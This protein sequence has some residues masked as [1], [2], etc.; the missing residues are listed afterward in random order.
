[1]DFH[2][3]SCS[4]QNS[5]LFYTAPSS[6]IM[7]DDST[8]DCDDHEF[9]FEVTT[10]RFTTH[11]Q[12]QQTYPSFWW[13]KRNDSEHGSY[14]LPARAKSFC[15]G[16]VLPLKPPPRLQTSACS[17]PRSPNSLR[18][19]FSRPCAWND[20]FDPFQFALEK[21]SDETRAR[22]SFHRR[23]QSYS[24]YRTSSVAHWLEGAVDRDKD[25]KKQ[26][27][28]PNINSRSRIINQ[29]IRHIFF[30]GNGQGGLRMRPNEHLKPRGP[31][32]AKMME[33]KESVYSKRV[34]PSE[35]VANPRAKSSRM[36]RTT[37]K[38]TWLQRR[39]KDADQ[40]H[41]KGQ[42]ESNCGRESKIHRVVS[43]LFKLKKGGNESNRRMKL[44]RCLGYAP[45]SP[46]FM[47]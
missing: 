45:G 12:F 11:C 22:M 17:S 9:E 41:M 42:R 43:F 1:M 28:N 4:P 10:R 47:K 21:V 15:S 40:E 36:A 46:A 18:L 27:F 32:L 33:H 14:R 6:P 7:L 26:E 19:R 20:D 29:V 31:T 5:Q 44:C 25:H 24:A 13:T 35:H 3:T 37:S 2:S 23:S 8:S 39:V 34:V 16:Q 38:G 30:S